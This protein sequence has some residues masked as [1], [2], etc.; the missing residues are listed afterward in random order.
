MEA[1]ET[2]RQ[3]AS[4][5]TGAGQ[6]GGTR[7]I[8]AAI[9]LVTLVGIALSVSNPLLSLEME[10]WGVSGTISGL[11]A[12]CAGFGTV[13]VAPLV[14]NLAQRFGVPLLIGI[15]LTLSAAGLAGFYFVQNVIAWALIRFALGC[16]LGLVFTLSEFWINAAA[17]PERRGFVMGLYA[18]ALYAGF[19]TG[20]A[21]LALLGTTGAL[22]YLATAAI[23]GLG[24]IPLLLAGNITPKI[25][26][27][28]SGSVMRFALAVPVATFGALVFGA[29]ETG[30]ITLLPVHN[31]RVGFTD[32]DAAL[33][34]SAFTLGNVLFQ[35]PFGILS[36]RVDRRWLLLAMATISCALALALILGPPS[37]WRFSG[38]L[39]LLGGVSGG[40]YSVGLAHLGARFSGADL[41]SAN[42][43]FVM[44]YSVGLMA[45]PPAV[46]MGMDRGGATGLPLT[47]ALL[48]GAYALIVAGRILINRARG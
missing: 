12:T 41:V 18:T 43:A 1:P 46:G 20:P 6:A 38:L 19:A 4:R 34:L 8:A 5:Q 45:G 17:P 36:D 3:A 32:Q 22:P 28:A 23:M 40:I 14:P 44:L 33:L 39:F 9:M 16:G 2:G 26:R 47:V 42:A 27:Q 37:F 31:V 7:V 13:L 48:L 30:V 35:L 10:R 24:L 15:A 25:E 11:T 21:I 29:C